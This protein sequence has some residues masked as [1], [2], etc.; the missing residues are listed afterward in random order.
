MI[1]WLKTSIQRSVILF[2]YLKGK[3][4]KYSKKLILPGFDGM[5][6]YDVVLFFFKGINQSSLISRANAISF[7]FMLAIFPGI[8]FFFTLIPYIPVENLHQTILNTLQDAV[9]QHTF[10]TIKDTISGIVSLHNG[11]LLSFGFLVALYFSTNGMLGLMKAFNRT[12]HTIET[13]SSFRLRVISLILVIV[14]TLIV[15]ISATLLIS[16]RFIIEYLEE[17]GI[18]KGNLNVIFIDLG[19]WV[20]TLLMIF[21]AIS[22][23]YYLAPASARHF[24]FISAGSTLSTILSLLFIIGF[25]FYI[26]NFG[27]YNEVYG[28]LG[29]LIV[30]MLWVNLNAIV[31]LIGFELNASISDAKLSKKGSFK[32]IKPGKDGPPEE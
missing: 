31:L 29:T 15:I 7:T 21:T 17:S 18:L 23:I 9:P 25:N 1:V 3:L 32:N 12:S 24:R 28:S 19:K 10:D 14:V 16:T 22:T 30:L 4:I 26:D 13:R 2:L 27:N 11:G 8:I 6:L 20:I 5:P